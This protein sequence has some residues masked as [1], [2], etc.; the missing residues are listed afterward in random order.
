[1]SSDRIA[2]L[3]RHMSSGDPLTDEEIMEIFEMLHML[4]RRAEELQ[5]LP[6]VHKAESMLELEKPVRYV[7][8]T[9]VPSA[10]H[11]SLFELPFSSGD[12]GTLRIRSHLIFYN[13]SFADVHFSLIHELA[14]AKTDELGYYSFP[15]LPEEDEKWWK[16][17]YSW[18]DEFYAA[19]NLGRYARNLFMLEVSRK[20]T[21]EAERVTGDILDLFETGWRLQRFSSSGLRLPAETTGSFLYSLEFLALWEAVVARMGIV[22]FNAELDAANESWKPLWN[23][24]L[25]LKSFKNLVQRVLLRLPSQDALTKEEYVEGGVKIL[26]S[27][28]MTQPRVTEEEFRSQVAPMVRRITV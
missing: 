25:E 13:P 19:L 10:M 26:F 2:E 1:M 24:R 27:G 3:E 20:I 8:V 15:P 23:G 6:H 28:Q 16:V 14:H 21:G 12:C 4:N 5:R 11:A 22:D 9:T 18:I 7:P 17:G